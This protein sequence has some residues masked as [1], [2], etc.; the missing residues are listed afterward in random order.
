M[1]TMAFV[2]SVSSL[3]WSVAPLLVTLITFTGL[4][5]TETVTQLSK[6]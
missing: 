3:I 1:R 4:Y 5:L 6:N 2:N